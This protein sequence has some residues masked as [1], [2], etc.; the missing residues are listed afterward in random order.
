MAYNDN[1]KH[2]RPDGFGFA[3]SCMYHRK[4]T[5][6]CGGGELNKTE[7]SVV[8][9]KNPTQKYKTFRDHKVLLWIT[10][11]IDHMYLQTDY[12]LKT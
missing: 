2:G 8:E 1:S 5:C 6:M 11:N 4:N 12:R 9:T 3:T 7:T 10:A